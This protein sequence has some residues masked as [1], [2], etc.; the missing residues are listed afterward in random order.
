MSNYLL[1][2][3]ATGIFSAPIPI[4]V[5]GNKLVSGDFNNDGK[6]DVASNNAVFLGIGNGSFSPPINYPSIPYV[7]GF[8]ISDYNGDGKLDV[9]TV[10]NVNNQVIILFG[11][12]SGS[13]SSSGVFNVG[14]KAGQIITRDFNNDGVNDI[15]TCNYTSSDVSILLGIGTGSF[16]AAVNYSVGTYPDAISSADYNDDGFLDI[17]V[18]TSNNVNLLTGLSNGTFSL[19]SNFDIGLSSQAINSADFNEDGKIDLIVANRDLNKISILLNGSPTIKLSSNSLCA[20][21]SLTISASGANSYAW[22]TGAITNSITVNPSITSAYSVSGPITIVGC[23]NVAVQNF[24]VMVYNTLPTINF[25]VSNNIICPGTPVSIGAN[26]A[27]YYVWNTGATSPIVSC[28]PSI[29][30]IYSVTGTNACG[31]TTETIAI[32][33]NPLPTILVNDGSICD[34]QSFTINP[35]GAISYTYSSGS[36]VVTPSSNVTYTISGNNTYGCIGTAICSVSVNPNPEYAVNSGS[37]CL[38]QTYSIT[39]FIILSAGANTF[40]Y[41]GGSNL[42]SPIANDTYTI[43]GTDINGCIGIATCS[44]LVNSLP[45]LSV[46]STNSICINS[47]ATINASGA[48]TYTWNTGSTIASINIT[49][50]ITTTYTVIGM[51]ANN[52]SNTQTVSVT[53]DNTCQDVWP[54]DAN[55]DGVAD[56]LDVLELGLHYTQTGMPRTTTSNNWQS[57]YAAN[58]SGSIT[59]GQNVNHSDCNGDGI[60]ND[61]DTLAIFNNYNLTH[62]FK[63]AQTTTNPLLTIVPDQSSVAKGVWG[64]SSINLGDATTSINNINGI[65]YTINYDNTLLETDSVWIEYPTSF[66]NAGNQNLKFRKRN[67]SNSKLYTATTHTLSGNVSGYGKIAI[68][69]YKIKST[70]ATDNVLNLSIAQTNLSNASGA[71]TPLTSG[72]ATL[73]AIGASVGLNELSNGNYI[74]LHPNPTN[75]ALTINSTTELQKIEVMA[76]TGQLLMSELPSNTNHTSTSSVTV[77]HLDHLANGVYFVNIYQNNCIVKREKIILNK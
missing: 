12:G 1:L 40:S 16:L 28:T 64:T 51:D 21:N 45:N 63:P 66:I 39:P 32:S 18:S 62:A 55:S 72:S 50:T 9:A 11:N 7:T 3:S 60:I 44:V 5:N 77:L 15:A 75:G 19:V 65:A 2:G 35:S 49:P 10:N 31:I 26:G 42:V 43:I 70:L 52:C 46:T 30:T 56:N 6:K 76:I 61:G 53:V 27:N 20:G 74:S 41:S 48:S 4:N 57:Y 37:I 33:V 14:G 24:S 58:W 59:N 73:M 54:G 29:T 13:F 68:L 23:E 67:F 47:N 36:S 8:T 22:S 38:G 17:A 25:T 69:H 34:G 71:I